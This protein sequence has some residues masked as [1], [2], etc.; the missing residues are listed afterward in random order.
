MLLLKKMS[1]DKHPSKN[2]DLTGIF[3]LPQAEP[4]AVTDEN[5]D[6]FAVNEM[7]PSERVD[8][9]ESID[10]LG[11]ID[12]A[13]VE[14]P[15]AEP[16][17]EPVADPFA[18][19]DAFAVTPADAPPLKAAVEP[20]STPANDFGTDWNQPTQSHERPVAT[21]EPFDAMEEI[22]Q[23][24]ENTRASNHDVP[25]H[26]PFHLLISGRFGPFERDKLLLFITE[27]QI[28]VGS[29][30]LDLQIKGGRVLFPRISEYAGI[31]LIQELRDSGLQFSLKPSKR[32]ED[33]PVEQAQALQFHF[34][35]ET[36]REP[37]A[38]QVLVLSQNSTL[39]PQYEEL[40]SVQT[41]QFIKA[42][43]VEVERSDL[44]QDVI[45][46][47]TESLKQK[48]KLKGGHALARLEHKISPLRLPSQYQ[49][50][51]SAVVMRKR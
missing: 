36:A 20:T 5:A 41:H 2:K 6:P 43:M 16:L 49:V 38:V 13:P 32:D 37:A 7:P 45:E 15:S 28:G 3:D 11:M 23:Y 4:P 30:D 12:H 10:Q 22:K 44:F 40:D 33:E 18:N 46:R 19:E 17:A 1:D 34:D 29:N 51:V 9:F 14:S 21:A 31:R 50:S 48:A 42:E 26:H 35:G 24:S 39:L 27:N 8:S 47:M 25:I